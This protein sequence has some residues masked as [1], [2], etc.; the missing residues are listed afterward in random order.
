MN[1]RVVDIV[2]TR[3]LLVEEQVARSASCSMSAEGGEA[4]DM[5]HPRSSVI[6]VWDWIA[7]RVLLLLPRKVQLNAFRFFG[8]QEK[9]RNQSCLLP[10]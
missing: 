9:S 7:W 4:T 2:L 8:V 6:R 1:S 10:G 5:I 3:M